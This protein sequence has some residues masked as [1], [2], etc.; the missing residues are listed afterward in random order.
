ME[1]SRELLFFFSA[2]GAFNGLI[3]G[4]YFLVL[5]KPKHSSNYF[6]GIL[7]LALS[8]RTGK[9]VFLYFNPYLS[10]VFLQFGMSACLFIGPSL[11]FYLK[12]IVHGEKSTSTWKFHFIPLVIVV[13]AIDILF[14]WDIYPKLWRYFFYSIYF[15]WF[16]YLVFSAWPIRTSFKDLFASNTKLSK[17]EIWILTIY[18]GNLLVWIAFNTVSYTSYIVG[19]LSFSF[20]FYIIVLLLIFTRKKDPDF[21][22]KQVKYGN[23]QIEAKEANELLK[24]LDQLM[25]EEELFKDPNIKLAD[26]AQRLNLLPHRLSQLVNEHLK[27]NFTQFINEYRINA[28]KEIIAGASPLKL[29]SIGYDCGFNSKSTFYAAFKKI[30]G[31]TPAK[32]KEQSI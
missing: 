2:L 12:S 22:N 3:L 18:I 24:K 26:I 15:I 4:L 27:K 17:M 13:I 16:V 1:T 8:I 14:P 31:T 30:E 20:V 9:S 23:N 25:L 7:L 11:Y 19:A 6:L 10:G 28:A 21:F 32:F 5:A 29:E